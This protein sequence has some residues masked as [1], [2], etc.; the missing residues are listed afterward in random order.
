[1]SLK[2]LKLVMIKDELIKD[3]FTPMQSHLQQI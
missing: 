1:M 2:P 3:N